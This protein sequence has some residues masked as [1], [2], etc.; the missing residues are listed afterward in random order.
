QL[1][2][3][4]LAKRT[5]E[6][7]AR[8][9]LELCYGDPSQVPEQRV[10]EAAEEVR[11]RA[12]LPYA[13]AAFMS[14]LRGLV[15]SYLERGSASLWRQAARVQAPTL[16]VWGSRDR[17]VDVAL[18]PRAAAAFPDCRLLVLPE[19]G[20]VAQL[21][22]PEVVARA[23]LGMREELAERG[24]AGD[25]AIGRSAGQQASTRAS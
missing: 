20:H 15:G 14:S 3:R 4:Q 1:A 25:G 16:L 24:T 5:P 17:L 13:E 6:Q 19:V 12:G 21:E 18:A 11:R 9:V 10:Q 8:A 2:A 7:R 23:F 22:R